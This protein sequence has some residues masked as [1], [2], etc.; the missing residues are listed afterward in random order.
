MFIKKKKKR[1]GI[2]DRLDKVWMGDDKGPRIYEDTVINGE[3][4][5]GHK[6]ATLACQVCAEQ[7]GYGISCWPLQVIEYEEGPKVLKDEVKTIMTPVEA[8]QKLEGGKD[9]EDQEDQTGEG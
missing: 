8:L 7:L 1:W 2:Y 9:D 4:I 5:G 3:K 6:L